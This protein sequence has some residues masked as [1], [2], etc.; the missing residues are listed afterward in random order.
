MAD[1]LGN[2]RGQLLEN[3][4]ANV[5]RV[6][7]KEAVL[8][9]VYFVMNARYQLQAEYI[10]KPTYYDE[11]EDSLDEM[12]NNVILNSIAVDRMWSYLL[13]RLP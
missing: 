5:T 11:P 2:K 6:N 8:S 10:G 1:A 7:L 13:D 4:G 9:T 12:V 3:H